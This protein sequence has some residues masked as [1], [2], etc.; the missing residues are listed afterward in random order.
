MAI[1]TALSIGSSLL[2]GI[3]G[4]SSAKKAARQRAAAIR[5]AN[6]QFRDPSE[7]FGQQYGD[8]GIYGE[9]AMSTILGRERELMPEFMDLQRMRAEGAADIYGDIQEQAKLRQLGMIGQMGG[10]IRSTLED[11]RLA[12]IAESQLGLAQQ[13]AA[14]A[15]SDSPEFN[16]LVQQAALTGAPMGRQ[17]D[18]SQ[19][20][21]AALSRQGARQQRSQFAQQ[22]L[23]GALQSASAASIDP[24]KFLFGAPSA[25]ERMASGFLSG[26]LSTQVTDPGQAYNI[27]SAE[28]LR[29]ANAILGQGLAKAQGTAS[30]GAI[31]GS[32]FGSI[33]SSLGGMNF[34]G[35]QPSSMI[36]SPMTP[37]Y[38]TVLS[39]PQGGYAQSAGQNLLK[40]FGF[41]P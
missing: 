15:Q 36:Q 24:Y 20:A 9:E 11:P 3:F 40:S 25:E 16:R 29:K 8:T 13:A 7:I 28:D 27:G 22:A 4:S 14:E 34:G 2:G 35:G 19:L 6:E 31:L 17:G 26:P 38:G 10:D 18:A 33:G 21:R 5:R 41:K 12:Q 30:S 1:G 23:G 37:G 32:M 39:A